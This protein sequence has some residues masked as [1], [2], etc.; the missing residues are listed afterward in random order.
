MSREVWAGNPFPLGPNWDG[1]G[2]NFSLFSENAERVE[3]CLFGEDGTEERIELS[4]KIAFNWHCYL[5]G[6][7]PGQQYGYRVHGA[8]DPKAGARFN[9]AK[10]LIDPAFDW[11][12]DEDVRP[13]T[14]WHETVIYEAHVKGFTKR[15]EGVREALRGTY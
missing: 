8:Y 10:L 4:E 3:L 13:R 12:D 2:T 7:G 5:P 9:P 1:E 11:Q 6:V 15:R 14:P